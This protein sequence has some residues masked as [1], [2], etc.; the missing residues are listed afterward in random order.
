[1]SSFQ[2]LQARLGAHLRDPAAHG[3]PDGCDPRGVAIY[4][5][6]V[7]RNVESAVASA[8]PVLRR[9]TPDAAWHARVRD[10]FARHACAAPQYNRIAEEF[11]HFLEDERG[12]HADDPPFLAELA[13]Y[14][15]VELAL[16]ILDRDV[17]AARAIAGDVLDAPLRVSPL[18]WTLSY[19]WP[20]HRIGP[21]F[22]PTDP[23]AAP[24]YLVVWRDA[25]DEVRFMEVNAVTARLMQ[26]A[27][28][29][30]GATGRALIEQVAREIGQPSAALEAEGRAMIARL[31]ERTCL[32][33]S[34]S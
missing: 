19:A 16:G 18:A 4:R 32:L 10:F 24:T 23:P 34:S 9:L 13:H 11:V 25:H 8:F 21:D 2:D 31:V 15:W 20:V 22:Q 33:P 17:P 29:R 1:M 7:F 30:D 5:D 3:V 12:V 27:E 28:E 6:L 26:L 14:E